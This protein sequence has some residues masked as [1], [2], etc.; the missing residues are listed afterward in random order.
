MMTIRESSERPAN[1]GQVALLARRENQPAV[2]RDRDTDL[3]FEDVR[4]HSQQLT[5]AD[6][7]RRGS[8]QIQ[9]FYVKW[10]VVS[11]VGCGRAGWIR[12]QMGHSWCFLHTKAPSNISA[13]SPV[14]ARAVPLDSLKALGPVSGGLAA[15]GRIHGLPTASET[16]R[17]SK[18]LTDVAKGLWHQCSSS[19]SGSAS[20]PRQSNRRYGKGFRP[21]SCR[22]GL[23]R[24]RLMRATPLDAARRPTPG[25]W[26]RKSVVGN[27][28]ATSRAHN[29]PSISARRIEF[30]CENIPE[31]PSAV[32][33][34]LEIN[35]WPWLR[36]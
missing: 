24:E 17:I 15:L 7:T 36:R 35:C 13:R 3:G 14:L 19:G 1:A 16:L 28:A 27:R 29:F 34:S 30:Y 4:H 9:S 18:P 12:R 6:F 26:G 31:K 22:T 25:R 32:S 5:T 21:R 33:N 8:Y 20:V 23:A 10:A 11:C 2:G